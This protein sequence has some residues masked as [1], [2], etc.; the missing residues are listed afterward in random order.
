M[1][2]VVLERTHVHVHVIVVWFL[3]IFLTGFVL[4]GLVPVLAKQTPG[5]FCMLGRCVATIT[6]FEEPA[7]SFLMLCLC[8][9]SRPNLKVNIKNCWLPMLT[10]AWQTIW[11]KKTPARTDLE[12]KALHGAFVFFRVSVYAGSQGASKNIHW[13]PIFAHTRFHI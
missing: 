11:A 7:P 2:A 13:H 12:T 6:Y 10:A 8:L 5:P 9:P 3:L 1:A 4:P